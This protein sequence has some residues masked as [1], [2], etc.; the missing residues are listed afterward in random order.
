MIYGIFLNSWILESLDTSTAAE[1][2]LFS[3]SLDFGVSQPT[4]NP[5]P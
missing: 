1:S 3:L 2:M 4:L 5:K